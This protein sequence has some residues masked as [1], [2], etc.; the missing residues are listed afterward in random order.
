MAQL[1]CIGLNHGPRK[2]IATFWEWLAIYFPYFTMVYSKNPNKENRE[3][4]QRFFQII[5]H[6]PPGNEHIPP[7]EKENHLQNGLFRG[8]GGYVTSQEGTHCI[9]LI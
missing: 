8:Y 1:P 3:K 5:T 2:L 4:N 9:G 6:Q 7:G